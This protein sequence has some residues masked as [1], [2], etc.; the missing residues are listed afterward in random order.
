MYTGQVTCSFIS[1]SN[2]AYSSLLSYALVLL[3]CLIILLP[4]PPQKKKKKSHVTSER[5]TT[6]QIITKRVTDYMTGVT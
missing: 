4:P 6:Y 3:N 5:H 2:C 1:V